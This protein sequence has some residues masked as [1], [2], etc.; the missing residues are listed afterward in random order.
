MLIEDARRAGM[1]AQSLDHLRQAL[2]TEEP[3]TDADQEF[4][5]LWPENVPI[6]RAFLAVAS[7]WRIVPRSAG[8]MITPMGGTIAPTVP[9]V[10]GLDYAG[11]RAGLDAEGF[12]I[13]PELWRGLR[14]M[15]AAAC[16]AFN[17]DR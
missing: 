6:V 1:D 15:E 16:A 2:A 5:G 17:E 11:V 10:I 7:Q 14:T 9:V 4:D 3:E 13:T 8:G 12:A